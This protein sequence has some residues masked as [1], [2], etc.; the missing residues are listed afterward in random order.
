MLSHSQKVVRL[1][2]KAIKSIRD[3][4]EDY[5]MFLANAGDLR[6]ALKAGKNETNPF[7]IQQMVKQLENFNSYWEHPDPYIP[8]DGI[9]G[10]KWQ[11]NTAP[12]SY[13]V[14]PTNHLLEGFRKD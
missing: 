8:C 13:V 14:D 3:Y 10:T 6:A 9:N 7:H 1:Y 5:D 12:A 11:R 4:S 2:R